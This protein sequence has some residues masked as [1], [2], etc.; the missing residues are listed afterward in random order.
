M[1]EFTFDANGVGS[2]GGEPY[3]MPSEGSVQAWRDSLS[4]K[5]IVPGSP[6]PAPPKSGGTS[7]PAISSGQSKFNGWMNYF[8]GKAT[9]LPTGNGTGSGGT[10]PGASDSPSS[11]AVTS[12]WASYIPRIAIILLGMIFV[13][14]GL[15][16]LGLS[17]IGGDNIA[18]AARAI[19]R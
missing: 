18:A 7:T 14:I 5:D 9:G 19:R 10:N 8:T 3:R 17:S 6:V 15:Y 12:N 2:F 4:L 11:S 13:L 16:A 1:A